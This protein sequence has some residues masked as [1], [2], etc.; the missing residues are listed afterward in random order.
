MRKTSARVIA[1]LLIVSGA[2]A[3]ARAETPEEWVKLGTRVHGAFGSF[4]PVGIR[5]GLDALKRLNAE[6]RGVIVIYLAARRHHALAPRMASGLPQWRAPGRAPC[7]S[8][9]SERRTV[10]WVSR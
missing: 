3:Q 10:S 4:I 5:I 6:P 2:I 9:R 8:P 1:L 7:K